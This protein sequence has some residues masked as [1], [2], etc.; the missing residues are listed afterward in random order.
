VDDLIEELLPEGWSTDGYG[1][2]S[3]LIAPDGCMIEQDG[4]CPHGYVSP[5]REMG[6]I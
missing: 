4:R 1:I 6:L 2:D 5:L 3:N